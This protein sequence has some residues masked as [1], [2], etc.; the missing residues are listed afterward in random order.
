MAGRAGFLGSLRGGDAPARHAGAEIGSD[1]LIGDAFLGRADDPDNR[2]AGSGFAAAPDFH[3][4]W[5]TLGASAPQSG[6]DWLSQG[7]EEAE[8]AVIEVVNREQLVTV[9]VL[10]A[11]S[12]GD[13]LQ[14][15]ARSADLPASASTSANVSR[16]GGPR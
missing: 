1:S 5:G 2:R 15:E 4:V 12:A 7:E 8:G 14:T 9:R 10:S 16:G 6:D 13:V 3:P 11:A